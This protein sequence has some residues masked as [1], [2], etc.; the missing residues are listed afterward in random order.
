MSSQFPQ[1]PAH[2][3]Q[4]VYSHQHW[5][6]LYAHRP[7]GPRL[8]LVNSSCRGPCGRT[9]RPASKPRWATPAAYSVRTAE[10]PA[11][12]PA[13]PSHGAG[14]GHSGLYWN[15]NGAAL[16]GDGRAGHGR[17]GGSIALSAGAAT[18]ALVDGGAGVEAGR[19]DGEHAGPFLSGD[20]REARWARRRHQGRGGESRRR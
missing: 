1:K 16:R 5:I 11:C 19:T 14:I 4:R 17:A 13:R 15:G 10:P 8:R 6:D 9:A 18:T 12:A 2:R 20:C 7:S 3:D